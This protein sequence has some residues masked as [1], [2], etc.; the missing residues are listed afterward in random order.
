[1]QTT[2]NPLLPTDLRRVVDSCARFVILPPWSYRGN[3]EFY[4]PGEIL[5][6]LILTE[7][8]GNPRAVRYEPAHDRAGRRDAPTDADTADQDDGLMEDDKSYGLMQVMGENARILCGVPPGV[9]MDFGFLF[10]PLTNISFGLR[11]LCEELG[12]V[13]GEVAAHKID[14]GQDL[15]R[16][17]CRYN[18]GP[19]GDDMQ[20]GDFRLR[21]YVDKVARN[22]GLAR[23]D[24]AR[25]NWK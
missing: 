22:A 18:G 11:I 17:L 14:P 7:S 23:A 4:S 10:D 19:T 8:N 5:E 12:A 20:G 6:G 2:G 24:K 3:G 15:E 9:P 1:M 16:A 13:R 21:A 25:L